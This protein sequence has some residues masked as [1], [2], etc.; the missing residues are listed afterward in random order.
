MFAGIG[1]FLLPVPE[2]DTTLEQ[3]A[4]LGFV[5]EARGGWSKN[6][7][8][9]FAQAYLEI[10][11]GGLGPGLEQMRSGRPAATVLDAEVR[12]LVQKADGGDES[13]FR[14]LVDLYYDR[15]YQHLLWRV[16]E[17]Q[18][19]EALTSQAFAA[20]RAGM[21][22]YGVMGRPFFVFMLSIAHNLLHD[23]LRGQRVHPEWS[24][25]FELWEG[26]MGAAWDRARYGRWLLL[27][28]DRRDAE[29]DALAARGIAA[30][31]PPP[32][33]ERLQAPEVVAPV[34]RSEAL[35]L[36]VV[37]PN[38]FWQGLN[39]GLRIPG[40]PAH[41][42]GATG[43]AGVT[44]VT[45]DLTELVLDLAKVLDSHRPPVRYDAAL[46]AYMAHYDV[47]GQSLTVAEPAGEGLAQRALA[48][49]GPGVAMLTVVTRSLDAAAAALRDGGV[50][51]TPL[52]DGPGLLVGPEAGGGVWLHFTPR[53]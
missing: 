35:F 9:R 27:R 31:L 40:P 45:P 20:A 42:N 34:L 53:A 14:Q 29:L 28:S 18:T 39:R 7:V 36:Q 38:R 44:V 24:G 26:P 13:A 19:A 41:P 46:G 47:H 50:S 15:V 21:T 51:A 49:L 52:A 30:D 3:Y 48:T 8:V 33:P 11:H 12:Q 32:A 6:G 16:G 17:P 43:L 25:P 37:G 23:Y 2:V 22:R 4:R 1:A 5:A 10:A